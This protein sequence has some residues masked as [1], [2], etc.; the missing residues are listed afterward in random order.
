MLNPGL[1]IAINVVDCSLRARIIEKWQ[2]V[3]DGTIDMVGVMDWTPLISD[4]DGRVF[5]ARGTMTVIFRQWGGECSFELSIAQPAVDIQAVRTDQGYNV[6]YTKGEVY[7]TDLVTCP[8]T[9]SGIASFPAPDLPDY[10]FSIGPNGGPDIQA[11]D[12]PFFNMYRFVLLLP[13]SKK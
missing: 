2:G 8:D 9:G 12:Y 1:Q 3:G 5:E 7:V 6:T 4:T 10:T 11:V 13:V